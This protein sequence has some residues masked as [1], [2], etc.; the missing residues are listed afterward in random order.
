MLEH[1]FK[2]LLGHNPLEDFQGMSIPIVTIRLRVRE[3][4]Q[5]HI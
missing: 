3:E 4:I 2:G 1:Q 5:D